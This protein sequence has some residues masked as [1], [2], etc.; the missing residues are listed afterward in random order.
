[1]QKS[2]VIRRE[3]ERMEKAN[4]KRRGQ[5]V[6]LATST[7]IGIVVFIFIVFASLFGIAALNPT[8]FFT[9]GSASAN[10]TTALQDNTTLLVSNFS[11]RLP[12]VGTVLG[13][14]LILGILGIM[15][16]VVMKF[17]QSSGTGG[18]L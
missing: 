5:V 12:V 9:S 1:M 15:I 17:K 6:N 16:L 14:V 2:K 7:V 4:F 13:V 3:M 10:A 8:S 18:T 11:Q